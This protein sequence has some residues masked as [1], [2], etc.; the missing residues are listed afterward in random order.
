M[1]DELIY[2]GIGPRQAGWLAQTL[3]LLVEEYFDKAKTERHTSDRAE[4]C[5]VVAH[6][7]T[8]LERLHRAMHDQEIRDTQERA[9]QGAVR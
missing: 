7:V 1:E 8:I 5:N 9:R 6:A 2:L 3:E 4:A